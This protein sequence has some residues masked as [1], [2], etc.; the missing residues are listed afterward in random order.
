MEILTNI[1]QIEVIIYGAIAFVLAVK[2][3]CFIHKDEEK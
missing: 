3:M 2:G 1:S